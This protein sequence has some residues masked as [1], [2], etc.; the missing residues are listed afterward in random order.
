MNT[1]PGI[2][3][4]LAAMAGFAA[5]QSDAALFKCAQGERIVYQQHPC[6][7]GSTQLPM[8]APAPGPDAES[9]GEAQA[10]AWL[11]ITEADALR[12][13]EA[14]EEARQR[15]LDAK[16]AKHAQECS[17][18]LARIQRNQAKVHGRNRGKAGRDRRK[19]IKE[20][21]PL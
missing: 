21:G 6:P 16:A 14:E 19:F 10:R 20:C 8:A 2:L 1:L 15:L 13:K 3:V 17:R 18:R 12:E 4:L 5:R 9:V 7:Q 11:D